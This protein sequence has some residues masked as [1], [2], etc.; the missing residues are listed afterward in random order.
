[1]IPKGIFPH[2]SYAMQGTLLVHEVGEGSK[3]E[4]LHCG[5]IEDSVED[6]RNGAIMDR[7]RTPYLE[8]QLSV[9]VT[10]GIQRGILPSAFERTVKS[11][12]ALWFLQSTTEHN[13]LYMFGL[14]DR[15]IP[16]V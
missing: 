13:E 12:T 2:I 6:D 9:F 7:P 8:H 11:I 1:M 10:D 16:F 14:L 15:V 3:V 5:E 4:D